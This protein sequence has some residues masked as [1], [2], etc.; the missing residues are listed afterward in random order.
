VL[1]VLAAGILTLA[2]PAATAAWP[3]C[4]VDWFVLS[5]SGDT[6]T[7]DHNGVSYNCCLDHMEWVVELTG[8]TLRI[9]EYEITPMP[10]TC[11]CCYELSVSVADCPSGLLEVEF[12]W[13]DSES[14]QWET[15]T[16][17]IFV[18]DVGQAPLPAVAS[19]ET[20]DCLPPGTSA[21]P[22]GEPRPWAVVKAWYRA[23]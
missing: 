17:T 7:V 22:P 16:G 14:G 19:S 3:G 5:A 9:F 2:T 10:C 20:S 12:H 1:V 21:P 8:S 4:E 18:P 6:V 15:W 23:R 11:L 13:A